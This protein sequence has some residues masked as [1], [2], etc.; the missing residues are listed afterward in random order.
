[1]KF[2]SK[3]F[4]GLPLASTLIATAENPITRGIGLTAPCVVLCGEMAPIRL[5]RIGIGQCQVIKGDTGE[6][7]R[8]DWLSLM[9]KN[10]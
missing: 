1:M 9:G 4:N 3:T 10:N 5:D 7:L 8:L 6:L 2:T